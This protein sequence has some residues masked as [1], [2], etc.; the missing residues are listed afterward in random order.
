MEIE[1]NAS[2]MYVFILH[3]VIKLLEKEEQMYLGIECFVVVGV[4]LVEDGRQKL[5]AAVGQLDVRSG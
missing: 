4:V 1:A 3:C 5:V 2:R